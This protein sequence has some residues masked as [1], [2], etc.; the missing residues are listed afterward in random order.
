MTGFSTIV[1]D[2]SIILLEVSVVNT[3]HYLSAANSRKENQH[4]P[5]L[6]LSS[7]IYWPACPFNL[8]QLRLAV[9]H[10]HAET[11]S[12]SYFLESEKYC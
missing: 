11:L 1:S 7:I 12:N 3:M 5:L 2:G 9:W 10:I 6:Y 4:S 8:L